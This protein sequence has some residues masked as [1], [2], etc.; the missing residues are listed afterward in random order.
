MI[1]VVLMSTTPVPV[2]RLFKID[3]PP[4]TPPK[5]CVPVVE[6]VSASGERWPSTVVMKSIA[7]PLFAVKVASVVSTT[8]PL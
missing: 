8:A 6:S 7:P 3:E 4:T 2:T 5:V 1:A